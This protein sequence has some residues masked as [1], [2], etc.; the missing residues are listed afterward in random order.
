M[1]KKDVLKTYTF[2][3]EGKDKS[4]RKVS[5]DVVSTT[6][7]FAKAELRKQGIK[8]TKVRKRTDKSGRGK[9]ITPLDIAFFTRQLA[10]MLKAGVPL[11]NSFDVAADS[12]EKPAVK[13]LIMMIKNDVAGGNNLA[14]SMSRHPEYFD[15]LYCSLVAAGEQAGRLDSTLERVATYKEKSEALKAKIKK[16]MTYPVAVVAVALLVTGIMLV[17][18]VPQFDSVFAG[19]GAE[20]PAFTQF[21]IHISEVLQDWWYILVIVLVVIVLSFKRLLKTSEVARNRVDRLILRLP[22]LGAILNRSA[23]ARFS[24]TLAT[25]FSAGVSLVDALDSVANAAGNVVYRQATEA[26]KKDVSTG[27]Q[28]Q[29][30]MRNSGVFPNMA[31]QMVAIGEES[32]SLDEMLVKIAGYYEEEVDNMIDNL[33]SLMEPIIM[34]VLGVLVGGLIIAMYLPIFQLGSVI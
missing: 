11:I 30:A 24:R 8:T 15:D 25:T 23:V 10:T 21:V 29:F 27:Q 31:I 18:V 22:I 34:A 32:G 3:W 28:L 12:I 13:Y 1:A 9:K 4:G 19:F 5:G 26:I 20:L 6:I 2:D 16:A 14:N 7:S 33:T 17:K